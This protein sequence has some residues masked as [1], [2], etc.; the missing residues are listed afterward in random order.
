MLPHAHEN[1]QNERSSRQQRRR[2]HHR[3]NSRGSTKTSHPEWSSLVQSKS[4]KS[5]TDHNSGANLLKNE[6][7]KK[8]HETSDHETTMDEENL[9]EMERKRQIRRRKRSKSPGGTTK[10]PEEILQHIKYNLVEPSEQLSADQLKEI[11]FVKIETKAPAFRISP[12][13]K[14]KRYSPF[15]RK[16]CDVSDYKGNFIYLRDGTAQIVKTKRIIDYGEHHSDQGTSK[17]VTVGSA[18]NTKLKQMSDNTAT[19]IAFSDSGCEDMA[20]R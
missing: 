13:Q 18:V 1:E 12:H 8:F 2:S 3:S 17:P 19:N 16:S 20:N 5:L 15:K 9:N 10:P 14:H 6:T 7:R 4:R 11:P